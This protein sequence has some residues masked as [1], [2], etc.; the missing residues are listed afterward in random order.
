MTALQARSILDAVAGHA[1]ASGWF[2]RVNRHEP[3]SKNPATDGVTCAIWVQQ[4]TPLGPA[5]GLAMTSTRLE[6]TVRVYTG[7]LAEPQDEIDPRVLDAVDGLMGAYNADF[8][9]G[10]LV[11]EVDVFGAYGAPLEAKAGYLRQGGQ[12]FRVVDIRVP[13]VVAD[14][15]PQAA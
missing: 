10:G 12:E 11:Q 2:E 9:L 13:L 4:L 14:L 8:E 1:L 6:I 5:S 15:W 7:L 3:K